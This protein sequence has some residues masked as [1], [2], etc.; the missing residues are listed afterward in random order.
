V[1]CAGDGQARQEQRG[2]TELLLS[3]L[4]DYEELIEIMGR[5]EVIG[6]A[7]DCNAR[8]GRV[9]TAHGAVETP[10]FMPVGTYGAVRGLTPRQLAETGSE[11]LLANTYHLLLRPGVEA[12]TE[13][14][15]LHKVMGWAGPILTDSGGYQLF[16]LSSLNR[17]GDGGVEFCSHIDGAKI[18]LDAK[19][20]TEAQ[21]RLGADIIMC[22][23]ECASYG[24]GR[25]DD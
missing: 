18:Y 14:G 24:C 1:R 3:R 9:R 13:L 7:K 8:R 17:I 5:F 10:V 16:S 11:I 4:K 12:V 6:Q 23:D 21:N 19:T 25:A 22:F 2:D 15:G 20:V